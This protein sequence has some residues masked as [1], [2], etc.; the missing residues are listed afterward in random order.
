MP[1]Q[2]LPHNLADDLTLYMNM[3]ALSGRNSN[4]PTPDAAI[5]KDK[6]PLPTPRPKTLAEQLDN[7]QVIESAVAPEYLPSLPKAPEL[8]VKVQFTPGLTI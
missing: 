7:L 1:V 8:P 6:R 5:A 3:S 2:T 4:P